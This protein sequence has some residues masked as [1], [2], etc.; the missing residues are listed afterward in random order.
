[1]DISDEEFEKYRAE[2]IAA[3][4]SLDEEVIRGHF[5]KYGRELLLYGEVFWIVIHRLRTLMHD[6]PM[7]ERTISKR[8]LAERDLSALDEGDVPS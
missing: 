3:V 7:T 2:L 5:L 6:L 4:L 1:M 8:W